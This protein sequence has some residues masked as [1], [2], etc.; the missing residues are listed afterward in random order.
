MTSLLRQ[1]FPVGEAYM[2]CPWEW[3]WRNGEE[4]PP[5]ECVNEQG[6]YT[7]QEVRREVYP[8]EID[9][10]ALK[11]ALD[12]RIIAPRVAAD[13]LLKTHAVVTRLTGSISPDEMTVDPA[14]RFAQDAPLRPR[15]RQA[16]RV[17]F[18]EQAPEDEC[19]WNPPTL[20][21]Y[22]GGL[23]LATGG[24][25]D[26]RERREALFGDM[27]AAQIIEEWGEQGE[28]QV[29]VNLTDDIHALARES[30]ALVVDLPA[31]AFDDTRPPQ[32][33]DAQ[34]GPYE[35]PSDNFGAAAE[36]ASSPGGGDAGAGSGGGAGT[37]LPPWDPGA[38]RPDG[39]SGGR[40]EAEGCA[41]TQPINP[42]TSSPSQI[43]GRWL[44]L[45]R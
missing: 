3:E 43:L 39:A 35:E 12:E 21:F 25:I 27:P 10:P 38:P 4:D 6:Y 44:P 37:T 11:A 24:R 42:T 16:A 22:E 7:G 14:F 36:G 23:R 2:F 40:T 33:G 41:C 32:P 29:T 31:D 17:Q 20:E 9:I 30:S 8:Q 18:C 26:E 1:W 34:C 5:A 15:I 45:R 13:R 19:W 28:A